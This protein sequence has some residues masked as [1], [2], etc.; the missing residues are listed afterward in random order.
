VPI[1]K[2]RVLPRPQ[3]RQ[4]DGQAMDGDADPCSLPRPSPWRSRGRRSRERRP[5]MP[6]LTQL[7][8]MPPIPGLPLP[9]GFYWVLWQP[10][11]LAELGLRHVVCLTAPGPS[12]DPMPLTVAHAAGL[13]DLYGGQFS[14]HPIR[15][16][17]LIHVAV[18]GC[19]A[20][21][22]RRSAGSLIELK[23]TRPC[24]PIRTLSRTGYFSTGCLSDLVRHRS[25]Q[26]SH[27]CLVPHRPSST[28]CNILT[29][30]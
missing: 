19:R 28:N 4:P 29:A 10:A 6:E 26:R 23:D 21:S 1:W 9:Y 30:T 18:R 8:D 2:V 25:R 24:A 22:E 20:L 13:Q 17:R 27:I 7:A 16:E 11:P 5:A 15:E 3:G 12:Y 14:H